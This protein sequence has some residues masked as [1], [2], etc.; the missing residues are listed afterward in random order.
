MREGHEQMRR[1][2]VHLSYALEGSGVLPLAAAEKSATYLKIA[3]KP[4]VLRAVSAELAAARIE[5]ESIF[6]MPDGRLALRTSDD[7]KAM[8]ILDKL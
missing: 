7:K 1:R 4:R 3:N 8:R 6:T 5:I 2:E